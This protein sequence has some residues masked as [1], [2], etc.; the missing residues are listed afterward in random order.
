[1]NQFPKNTKKRVRNNTC[2]TALNIS[3]ESEGEIRGEVR[4]FPADLLKYMLR[5]EP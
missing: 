2:L 3:G 4:K 5:L 1:M